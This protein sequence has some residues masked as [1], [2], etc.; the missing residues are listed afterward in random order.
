[1]NGAEIVMENPT[2]ILDQDNDWR[3]RKCIEE[4]Q[5]IEE[6]HKGSWAL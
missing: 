6:V 1:M 4:E 5:L 3:T 2:Q